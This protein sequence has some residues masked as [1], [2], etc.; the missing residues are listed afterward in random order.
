M[1]ENKIDNWFGNISIIDIH[2][3]PSVHRKEVN[4]MQIM[5]EN[6]I[7]I[8]HYP[9]CQ[10]IILWLP[11]YYSNYNSIIIKEKSTEKVIFDNKIDQIISGSIQFIIDSL[12]IPPGTYEI[13]ILN[14]SS[15]KHIIEF[16]KHTDDYIPSVKA[17]ENTSTNELETILNQIEKE[18][19]EAIIYRDGIGK[20]IPNVDLEMREKILNELAGKF[21]RKVEYEGN[22][23]SGIIIYVENDKRVKFDTEMGGGNCLFYVFLPNK[24]RWEGAT[25]IPISERDNVLEF[26]AISANRD[27][28]SSCYYEI[29]ED[30][31]TYY[32]R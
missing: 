12:F 9:D 6:S 1:P 13:I 11:E 7:K 29:T 19:K 18:E 26:I 4:E 2:N 30:Y 31:I 22:L 10:Q 27:Q 24:E 21:T 8:V 25:G 15:D 5:K 17:V 28:A 16:I 32:R 14:N 23:R 20:I 3:N